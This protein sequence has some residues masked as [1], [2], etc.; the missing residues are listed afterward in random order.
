MLLLWGFIL[1][2][3]GVNGTD[4]IVVFSCLWQ[5][6]KLQRLIPGFLHNAE[7]KPIRMFFCFL[8]HECWW[9]RTLGMEYLFWKHLGGRPSVILIHSHSTPPPMYLATYSKPSKNSWISSENEINLSFT[10]ND[11]SKRLHPSLPH[12]ASWLFAEKGNWLENMAAVVYKACV[13]GVGH[14][15][16]LCI[17]IWL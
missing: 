2:L 14:C 11:R 4:H 3:L 1:I 9:D 10:L 13:L 5:Q 16:K 7:A 17:I 6:M 12:K 15:T 8:A